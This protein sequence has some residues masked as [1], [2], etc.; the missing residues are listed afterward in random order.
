MRKHD[1]RQLSIQGQLLRLSTHRVVA[2]YLRDGAAWVAEFVDGQG[3]LWEV[4]T[5]LQFN[6]GTTANAYAT[7]R[8]ALE[9]AIPL[10]ADIVSRIEQ[11]HHAHLSAKE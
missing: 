2:I 8:A 3:V 5:W 10:S 1:Y 6:C 9:S 7:H 4:P 11:L